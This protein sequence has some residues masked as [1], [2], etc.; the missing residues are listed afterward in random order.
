MTSPTP[1]TAITAVRREKIDLTMVSRVTSLSEALLLLLVIQ[2]FKYLSTTL[3][4]AGNPHRIEKT[5]FGGRKVRCG[6]RRFYYGA[7]RE[8]NDGGYLDVSSRSSM[9][10]TPNH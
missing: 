6:F 2:G 7:S 3:V 1:S 10:S 8:M 9:A 4:M 5:L